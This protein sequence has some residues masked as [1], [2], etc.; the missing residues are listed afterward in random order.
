[1]FITELNQT[2]F[3]YTGFHKFLKAGKRENRL[4]IRKLGCI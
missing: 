2:I 3:T 4:V 1:M